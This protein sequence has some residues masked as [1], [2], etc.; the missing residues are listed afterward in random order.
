MLVKAGAHPKAIQARLGHS[1]IRVTLDTY[2]HLFP[3]L[4]ED[5]P[6]RLEELRERRSQVARM[7]H[8]SVTLGRLGSRDSL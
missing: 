2:G 4:E 6:V 3:N 7:W 5:L 1:S 8:E